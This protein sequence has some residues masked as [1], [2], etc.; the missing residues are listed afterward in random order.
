[1]KARAGAAG[2]SEEDD[3][4]V[5]TALGGYVGED[6]YAMYRDMARRAVS[7]A[8]IDSIHYVYRA[9]PVACGP[10]GDK[11]NKKKKEKK[12]ESGD[13]YYYKD[14][15]YGRPVYD[16]YNVFSGRAAYME[17]TGNSSSSGTEVFVGAEHRRNVSDAAAVSKEVSLRGARLRKKLYQQQQQVNAPLPAP[18]SAAATTPM[19][20]LGPKKGVGKAPPGI[21]IDTEMPEFVP[22]KSRVAVSS[23]SQKVSSPIPPKAGSARA[24]FVPFERQP[25]FVKIDNKQPLPVDAPLPSFDEMLKRVTSAS[26][27]K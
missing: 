23:P 20:P 16:A 12:E 6:E 3:L 18:K 1:L 21:P 14:Y 8:K 4:F 13:D 19:P 2:A 9:Q 17:D 27:N 22:I 5:S 7:D 24:T 15:Y 26:K 25:A 11:K 10:C